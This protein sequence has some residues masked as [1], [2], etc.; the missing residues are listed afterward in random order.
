[1]PT[2]PQLRVLSLED[3]VIDAEVILRVLQEDGMA[4]VWTRVENRDDYVRAIHEFHPDLILADYK[5]PSFDGAQALEMAK[6]LCPDVPVIVI[7]GAVGE[8]TAVELIKNGATDFIIKDRLGRLVPAVHRALL[9]VESRNARRKAEADLHALNEQLEHRVE[10]RTR[11]LQEKNAVMQEDLEMAREL[12]MAFFPLNFPTI[13][14]GVSE[15]ASAVKFSSVFYPSSLVSGDFYKI[16]RIS[17]TTVGIFICDVMGH[18]VRAAL[19]TAIMRALV[20]R[21]LEDQLGKEAGDPGAL[22]TQINRQMN[23]ILQQL[24]ATMFASACYVTVDIGTGR[25]TFANAGHPYPL[26][27]RNA[28]G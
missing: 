4:L 1:M 10:E 23:V 7:S 18:G 3:S 20:M 11:E 22:L 24:E 5:L 26:L 8:E 19:V 21:D 12:Q 27:V 16:V 28:T 14:Q 17:D 6:T 2:P 9:E 25:L 15:S 13:P